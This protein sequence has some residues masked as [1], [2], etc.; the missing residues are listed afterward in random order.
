MEQ[1]TWLNNALLSAALSVSANSDALIT[2]C[3]T[4]L[5]ITFVRSDGLAYQHWLLDMNPVD[6]P[7]PT[8]PEATATVPETAPPDD[9]PVPL[10]EDFDAEPGTPEGLSVDSAP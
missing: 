6:L 10:S 3:V 7:V 8:T 9:L 2:I 5:N 4:P 1:P